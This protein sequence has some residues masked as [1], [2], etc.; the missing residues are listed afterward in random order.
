MDSTY[1]INNFYKDPEKIRE[2]AFTLDFSIKVNYPGLRTPKITNK[3]WKTNLRELF[4][5]ILQIKIMKKGW[6]NSE[7]NC[8]FQI[9]SENT[10]SWIHADRYTDYAAICYLTPNAPLNSGTSIYRHKV[11]GSTSY[12]THPELASNHAGNNLDQ[13]EAIDHIGNVYNRLIIYKGN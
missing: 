2:Y 13:W 1:I 8:A 7:Y 9:I 11:T 4:E 10:M 12:K 6:N 3:K 5:S